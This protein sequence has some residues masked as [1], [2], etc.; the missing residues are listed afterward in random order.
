MRS[1]NM[2]SPGAFAARPGQEVG[3][4]KRIA[5]AKRRHPRG[6]LQGLGNARPA[7]QPAPTWS[8]PPGCHA[9]ELLDD[10]LRNWRRR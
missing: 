3:S 5:A 8:P 1:P 7:K 4:P 2:K 10:C 6:E 9:A